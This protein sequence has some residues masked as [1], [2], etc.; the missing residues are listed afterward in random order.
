MSK[1]ET[2]WGDFE[3]F[4]ET[5]DTEVVEPTTEVTTEIEPD[6]T[7]AGEEIKTV[8]VDTEEVSDIVKAFEDITSSLEDEELLFVPEDKQYE[9]T[10]AGFKEMLK[11]NAEALKSKLETE[12]QEK[13]DKLKAEYED[14]NVV[15]VADLDPSVEEE[16]MA[17][18]E[19]YYLETGF[20]EDEIKEKLEEVKALDSFEK[21]AKVAQ[22]F[23]VKQEKELET[24]RE[25]KKLKE[26]QDKKAEIDNY[27]N[28][29]KTKIDEIEEMAGFKLTPK[30]K[31]GF[32]DYIFKKDKEGLTQAQRAAQDPDRRLRLAFLDYIDY[33]KKDVE[34]KVKTELANE[35]EKKR[36]RFTST[37][38]MSKGTTVERKESQEGLPKG[39]AD[40]WNGNSTETED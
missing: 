27:V 8:V 20:T 3:K 7:G 28:S 37:Q 25:Q 15:R 21:E 1:I 4:E 32:K 29:I 23:L 35:F 17:M 16:A 2:P 5:T 39:F 14:N 33:N 38:A 9:P 6:S 22:R 26:E 19:R 34:I 11:D 36:S 10:P 18:L 12:F 40:F 13:L 31:S 24:L 30:V